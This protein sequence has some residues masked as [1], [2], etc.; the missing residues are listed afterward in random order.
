MC[1]C[2]YC[3]LVQQPHTQRI[4]IMPEGQLMAVFEMHEEYIR[5]IAFRLQVTDIKISLLY[6]EILNC[7]VRGKNTIN[8]NDRYKKKK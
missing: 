3:P 2:F 5:H 6:M 4:S 8:N 7:L 1:Y